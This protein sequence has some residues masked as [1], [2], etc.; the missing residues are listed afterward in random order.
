MKHPL[1]ENP[2]TVESIRGDMVENTHRVRGVIINHHGKVQASWGNVEAAIYPRS[3]LKIMQILPLFLSGAYDH[4]GFSDEEIALGCSSHAGADI[5]IKTLKAILDKIGLSETHLGCGHAYPNDDDSKYA[6]IKAGEPQAASYHMCSGKH[7]MMLATAKYLDVAI[8][9]Y[10]DITHPIQQRVMG[11]IERIC[12]VDLSHAPV[13]IDGCSLPNWGLPLVNMAY[14]FAKIGVCDDLPSDYGQAIKKIRACVASH[15]EYVENQGGGAYDSFLMDLFK[16]RLF[17]KSGA[18]GCLF[19]ALPE[20]GLG[21]GVK[22]DDGSPQ[23]A[24]VMMSNL[25]NKIGLFDD[26]SDGH[27]DKINSLLQPKL[28]NANHIITG[29]QRTL[30]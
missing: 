10:V 6:L 28:R 25:L 23:A 8:D 14:G 2:I 21:V 27:R 5:H 30:I 17:I 24:R 15:P 4:Y 3:S 12:E 7:A 16:E 11:G 18:D 22:C 9:D 13:G 29:H 1:Q 20:Y 26:I 19:A